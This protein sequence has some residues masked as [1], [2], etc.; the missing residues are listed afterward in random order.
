MTSSCKCFLVFTLSTTNQV[1]GQYKNKERNVGQPN[2]KGVARLL[3]DNSR[4][5]SSAPGLQRPGKL[6]AKLLLLLPEAC[7]LLLQVYKNTFL[8]KQI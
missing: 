4:L 6:L 2:K 7:N 1:G 3:P 8:V 5:L